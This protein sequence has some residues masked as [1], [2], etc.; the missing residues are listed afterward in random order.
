[1][2]TLFCRPRIIAEFEREPPRAISGKGDADFLGVFPADA[3]ALRELIEWNRKHESVGYADGACDF[4]ACAT[5]REIA[6][7]AID[8][9]SFVDQN[10]AGLQRAWS[11]FFST[12]FYFSELGV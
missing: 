5:R 10:L 7:H 8:G 6:D 4:Q 9:R 11:R 2:A 1:L 3:A 12:F